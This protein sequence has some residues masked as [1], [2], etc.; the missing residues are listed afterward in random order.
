MD[1]DQVSNHQSE[2]TAFFLTALDFRAQH[3]QVGLSGNRCLPTPVQHPP[4]TCPPQGDLARTAQ[5]EACVM[6][7]L[8]VMVM[9]LSEVTFR[10]LFF[11]VDSLARRVLTGQDV[12]G[13]VC[14]Q[15]F[16]WS[17]SGSKE[18]QLTFCRLAHCFAER[19][20]GLFVLFAGN[21]VKPFADVLRQSG[22]TCSTKQPMGVF[23]ESLPW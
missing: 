8:V 13:R 21:L 18:R 23:A 15:M 9:K 20:R 10:P 6:D 2:L 4:N 7:C 14:P 3:C 22:D 19:L 1:R 11:K 5:I 16:D 17:K 12:I